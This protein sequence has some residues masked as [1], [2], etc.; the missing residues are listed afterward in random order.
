M[1]RK[2]KHFAEATFFYLCPLLSFKDL[3][4]S[5]RLQKALSILWDLFHPEHML[6][7]LLPSGKALQIDN[8]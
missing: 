8:S 2:K 5:H 6:L 4:S 7:Q 3:Y 1:E